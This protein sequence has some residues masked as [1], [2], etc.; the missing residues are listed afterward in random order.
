L[1]HYY[2]DFFLIKKKVNRADA[3]L[4]TYAAYLAKFSNGLRFIHKTIDNDLYEKKLDDPN[5]DYGISA[6]MYARLKWNTIHVL[7]V[8]NIV[9]G[10]QYYK[11]LNLTYKKQGLMAADN[12]SW[13]FGYIDSTYEYVKKEIESE[14]AQFFL[15]NG[16]DIVKE[17]TFSAWFP[18]QTSVSE[19]MGDTKVKRLNRSLITQKQILDMKQHLKPGDII[20]E[21]RNWFISNIGL[22][23]FWPHA[24]LYVG[25]LDDMKLFFSDPPVTKYYQGRGEYK[26]FIDYLNS[27]Y[28]GKMKEY[29][30]TAA[31]GFP[32][33]VIEAV[34]EGVRFSS[35]QEATSADYIGV[36]RPRLTKLDIAKAVDEAFGYLGRPY[37]FNFD[38]LTDSSIVCSELIYKVYQDGPGKRGLGLKLRNIAGRKAMPP[39]DI[40][41]KFDKEFD[42]A[43]KELDFVYFLDGSEGKNKA[44]VEGPQDFRISYKRPKWD[45][46]QK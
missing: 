33:Q 2:H 46:A 26:D 15:A 36:L 12:S 6:G 14:G 5:P 40:V 35:L 45:I 38:F 22:P 16:L 9:A 31:D 29:I 34:S 39:N 7:D 27:K 18:V 17:K 4:L 23:G 28:P 21:R 42:T 32:H 43:E 11:L 37:D 25:T 1:T 41:Q 24:E 3:F 13:I 30:K 20:V 44:M 10:Y 8:S 19:W